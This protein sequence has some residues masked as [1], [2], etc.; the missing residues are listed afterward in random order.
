MGYV[1]FVKNGILVRLEDG[2][3]RRVTATAWCDKCNSQQDPLGGIGI[4]DL[5]RQVILW[6]CAKCR[7]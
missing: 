7:E 3:V 2:E 1:E 6:I 5:D 4:E